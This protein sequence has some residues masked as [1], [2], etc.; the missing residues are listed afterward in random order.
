[1]TKKEKILVISL[2]LCIMTLVGIILNTYTYFNDCNLIDKTKFNSIILKSFVISLA[3]LI[4]IV[5]TNYKKFY[6]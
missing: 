2:M 4:T 3:I 5:I 6:K 1:M